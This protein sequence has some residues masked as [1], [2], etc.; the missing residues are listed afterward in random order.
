MMIRAGKYPMMKTVGRQFGFRTLAAIA[1]AAGY[2]ASAGISPAHAQAPVGGM[3]ASNIPTMGGGN[4]VGTFN[5]PPNST[6]EDES[7]GARVY[8]SID[9]LFWDIRN[10]N[11]PTVLG[12]SGDPI[13]LGTLDSPGTTRLGGGQSNYDSAAP[14]LKI[15]FGTWFDGNKTVGSEFNIYWMF[16]QK[17]SYSALSNSTG[18]PLIARPYFDTLFTQEDTR[19]LAFPDIYSGGYSTQFRSRLWGAEV[20][21]YVCKLAGDQTSSLHYLFGFKYFYFNESFQIADRSRAIGVLP[22]TYMGVDYGEG[23]NTSVLDRVTAG[24]NF[25]GANFGLKWHA[26]V[27]DRVT[28]DIAGKVAFGGNKEVVDRYGSTRLFTPDNRILFGTPGG[29]LVQPSNSG[30]FSKYKLAYLPELNLGIGVKIVEG[31]NINLSYN[32][33]YLSSAV[34]AGDQLGV[35]NINS[36]MVPTSPN[37]GIGGGGIAP[38]RSLERTDFSAHSLGIG[39]TVSY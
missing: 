32:F 37:I 21:P 23:F 15:A 8:G 25:Y 34:R 5:A 6:Y 24:N 22:V 30:K 28:F 3:P 10:K 36:A 26:E 7:A 33:L 11:V 29:L 19:R 2:G 20:S 27:F 13:G 38:V 12:T 4:G 16:S 18:S 14:G 1:L 31:I 9:Y 17:I 39:L 35:R